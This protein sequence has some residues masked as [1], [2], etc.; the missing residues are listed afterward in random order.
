[1]LPDTVT[2]AAQTYT[3]LRE[4]YARSRFAVVPLLPSDHDNGVTTILEAFAMGRPVICT[5][6][7]GQVGLV[8]DGVNG[9][10]VPPGDA[11]AL[12][13]AIV[14]LWRDP[15][16]CARMGAAG[17]AL[18]LEHHGVDRWTAT[19]LEAVNDAVEARARAGRS[20]PPVRAFVERSPR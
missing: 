2:V 3:E 17:R 16:R 12:R 6:S 20:R 11:V 1:L 13:G 4:L 19:L 10:R 15:D 9:L 18:V 7:P 14:E 5:D 8:E